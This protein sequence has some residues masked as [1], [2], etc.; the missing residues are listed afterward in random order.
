MAPCL[1]DQYDG[2]G[3][4]IGEI[5]AAYREGHCCAYSAE[6]MVSKQ[7]NCCQGTISMTP[8]LS[9]ILRTLES[10]NDHDTRPRTAGYSREHFWKLS[11]YRQSCEPQLC[12]P[13]DLPLSDSTALRLHACC[14]HLQVRWDDERS[15]S[16]CR[17]HHLHH[18]RLLARSDSTACALGTSHQGKQ[19]TY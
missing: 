10:I 7:T 15:R 14:A 1:A 17:Y 16:S 13:A 6:C 8:T 5:E 4:S 3:S 19:T 18:S 12:Q 11:M 2:L 9:R